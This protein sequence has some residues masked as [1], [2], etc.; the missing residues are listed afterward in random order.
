M[1]LP[2]QRNKGNRQVRDLRPGRWGRAKLI[3]SLKGIST[4]S[5]SIFYLFGALLSVLPVL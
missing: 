4:F 1:F 2:T 3:N 5:I